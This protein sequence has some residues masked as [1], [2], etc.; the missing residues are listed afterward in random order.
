MA[1]NMRGHENISKE[2]FKAQITAQRTFNFIPVALKT[3]KNSREKRGYI[4]H[5]EITLNT[6]DPRMKRKTSVVRDSNLDWGRD[7]EVKDKGLTKR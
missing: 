4:F 5:F 3:T 7:D 2:M 6:A 1:G